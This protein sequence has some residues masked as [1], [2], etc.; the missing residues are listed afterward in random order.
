[1]AEFKREN[2]DDRAGMQRNALVKR[3]TGNLLGRKRDE[4]TFTA[5][6]ERILTGKTNQDELLSEVCEQDA[7]D[8]KSD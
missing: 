7:E 8:R 2:P 1:M 5:K 3:R 4:G 6:G